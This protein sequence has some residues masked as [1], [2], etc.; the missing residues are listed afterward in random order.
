MKN[1]IFLLLVVF[2][3]CLGL[4]YAGLAGFRLQGTWTAT[5]GNETEG[6]YK[7]YQFKGDDYALKGYPP[8]NEEGHYEIVEKNDSSAIVVLQPQEGKAYLMEISRQ[9]N[10]TL[11]FKDFTASG[12]LVFAPANE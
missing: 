3:L 12:G 4:D 8:L 9:D 11:L 10:G 6:W 2:L 7:S 1:Y 5:G